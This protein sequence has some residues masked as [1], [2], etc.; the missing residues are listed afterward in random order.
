MGMYDEI[1]YD[2]R[3]CQVKA[4]DRVLR[5]YSVGDFVPAIT[6]GGRDRSDYVL[7]VAATDGLSSTWYVLVANGRI[8]DI[9]FDVDAFADIYPRYNE[10]DG[11]Y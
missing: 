1:I 2:G 5:S 6:I 3:M 7:D 4:W 10:Y 9:S 8:A 11:E